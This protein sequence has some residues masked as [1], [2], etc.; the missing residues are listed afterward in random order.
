[1]D[2]PVELMISN[3]YIDSQFVAF[4][5]QSLNELKGAVDTCV[6]VSDCVTETRTDWQIGV[7]RY[8]NEQDAA[9][10]SYS[11]ECSFLRETLSSVT[12]STFV[13]SNACLLCDA[14][15]YGAWHTVLARV[16]SSARNSV[17]E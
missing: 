9:R 16:V 17:L 14:L 10:T 4:S 5:P 13:V 12:A 1:M 11:F 2:G 6:T 3:S 8:C 15:L 7:T